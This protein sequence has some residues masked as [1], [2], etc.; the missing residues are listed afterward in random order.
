MRTTEEATDTEQDIPPA[1]SWAAPH[2]T[3]HS[4]GRLCVSSY[5]LNTSALPSCSLPGSSTHGG[6]QTCTTHVEKKNCSYSF[7]QITAMTQKA[8]DRKLRARNKRQEG[9]SDHTVLSCCV[10]V[11]SCFVACQ[12]P[13]SIWF[14]R[15][16]HWSGLPCSPPGELSNSGIES[17]K[18]PALADGLF[19]TSTTWEALLSS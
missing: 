15:Q 17:L 13:L 4:R 10:C 3:Y 9:E 18:S 16:E 7:L 1:V 6:A 19:T 2:A 14:S 5:H 8:R 11:L 12:V